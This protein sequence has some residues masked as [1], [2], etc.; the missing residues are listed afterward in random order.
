[1]YVN[2]DTT[3]ITP[4]LSQL[5]SSSSAASS[6][7]SLSSSLSFSS[8]SSSSTLSSSLL[9]VPVEHKAS[10]LFRE[11]YLVCIIHIIF[12]FQFMEEHGNDKGNAIWAKN[13]PSCY[14]RP[15]PT[16]AQ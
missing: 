5:P 12:F 11:D 3:H 8:S 6:S 9:F 10:Q 7:S 1:M 2:S 14:R 16:D 4:F 15:K 13:V